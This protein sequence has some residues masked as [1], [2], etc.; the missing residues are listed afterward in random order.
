MNG[1]RTMSL[2]IR[3]RARRVSRR[4]DVT[5]AGE[6]V[7]E[8]WL[9]YL[10]LMLSLQVSKER[11][12][13]PDGWEPIPMFQAVYHPFAAQYGNYS[14]LTMPPYD[15]LWPKEFAPAEPLKLL[16]RKYSQ[17]FYLEQ[18][19]AFVWG[20]QPTIAN[21]QANQLDERADEIQFAIELARLRQ[22]TLPY[23]RDGTFV[24]IPEIADVQRSIEMSRLSIYAGQRGG[25]TSFM[26]EV[27]MVV[28]SVWKGQNRKVGI[29]VASIDDRPQRL[30]LNLASIRS[31]LPKAGAIYKITMQSR[32]RLSKW[33]SDQ[34]S[35]AL[36]LQPREACVLEI[37]P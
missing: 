35:I 28:A 23:L 6:G 31:G 1:F 16:D 5:L 8:S 29:A 32:R 30:E 25:L 26:K 11:Y 7:G 17:Q 9:P 20:Q 10:D 24:G 27:P 15:D 13:G 36:E 19:R 14:S 34:P 33:T 21:I 22:K 2:D 18:A 3:E 4:T 37:V 12:A